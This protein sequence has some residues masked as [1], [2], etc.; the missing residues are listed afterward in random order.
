MLFRSW[1]EGLAK[2]GVPA[3]PV[4]DISQ[5]FHDPQVL[6]RGMKLAMPHP[7]AGSGK[8][9]L[10]ANPIKYGETPIDY[11][12]PPPRLGEHTGEVLRELLALAP[13]EIA[14]LREAGVV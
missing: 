5:V 10:I 1:I 3:S 11:R 14:R 13:D 7:G 6:V 4:N 2:A 12:L 9:D 8:V